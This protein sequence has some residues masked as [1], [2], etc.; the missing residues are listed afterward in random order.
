LRALKV[1]R[2]RIEARY[3]DG[4]PALFPATVRSW[5]GQRERTDG[6]AAITVQLAELEGL[7]PMPADDPDTFDARV[8]ELMADHVEPARVKALDEMGEGRR[9]VSV[10]MAWLEPKLG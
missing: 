7:A 1:A 4:Y 9:A 5:L 3:L 8:A 6:L 2:E 10:A